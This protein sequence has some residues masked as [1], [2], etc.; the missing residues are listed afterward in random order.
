MMHGQK[1]IKFYTYTLQVSE[2][3]DIT[4]TLVKY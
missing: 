3:A 1:N 2:G 4:E